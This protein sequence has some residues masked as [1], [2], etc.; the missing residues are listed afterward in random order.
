ML[1]VGRRSVARSAPATVCFMRLFQSLDDL[2]A[3][4]RAAPDRRGTRGSCSRRWSASR[5][6]S[7]CGRVALA[8]A[9]T[10]PSFC[11]ASSFQMFQRFASTGVPPAVGADLPVVGRARGA[12][13]AELRELIDRRRRCSRS[14]RQ[15]C[16][17]RRCR[18]ARE[19]SGSAGRIGCRCRH[20][21]SDHLAIRVRER[22]V[23]R[24][25]AP[26]AA[27]CGR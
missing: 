18:G 27:S 23:L 15:A 25:L 8:V 2:A 26:A 7:G 22:L 9:R 14:P 24:G 21:V 4:C 12:E 3:P 17:Q 5:A 11:A 1:P 13:E 16:L 20:R 10:L 6:R 19:T